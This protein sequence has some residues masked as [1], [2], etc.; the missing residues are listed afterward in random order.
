MTDLISRSALL[1]ALRRELHPD[2]VRDNTGLTMDAVD[3]DD[4]RRVINAEL[5]VK[6]QVVVNMSGGLLQGAS[7]DYP[8]DIYVLDFDLDCVANE[9]E[10]IEVDGSLSSFGQQS[11]EVDPDFVRRVIEAPA[12]YLHD[13]SLVE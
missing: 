11:A 12:V 13:G 4:V 2:P 3:I 9:D 6:P 7:A 1:E 10:G 8:V 5:V